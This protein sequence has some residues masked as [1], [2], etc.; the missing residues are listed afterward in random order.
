MV[1]VHRGSE[2]VPAA[3][4]GV[5]LLMLML[6]VSMVGLLVVRRGRPGC[7]AGPLLMLGHVGERH[8][9][10]TRWARAGGPAAAAKAE[11]GCVL[12]AG[13]AE[14]V[15]PVRVVRVHGR[16]VRALLDLDGE[17]LG[18]MARGGV[19]LLCVLV[20]ER[21]ADGIRGGG[22]GEGRGWSGAGRRGVGHGAA[23][24]ERGRARER[25]GD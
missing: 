17:L 20:V 4:D 19:L 24:S 2:A 7:G 8:G 16:K 5:C 11:Y 10:R 1:P 9:R 21:I 14:G 22:G 15:R 23:G 6:L 25:G 13:G 3:V 12:R 18:V